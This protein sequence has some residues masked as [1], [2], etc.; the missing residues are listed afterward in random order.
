MAKMLIVKQT[1]NSIQNCVE[2]SSWYTVQESLISTIITIQEKKVKNKN[3]ND[4]VKVSDKKL[5]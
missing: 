3:K 2:K 5:L 4:I 1:F